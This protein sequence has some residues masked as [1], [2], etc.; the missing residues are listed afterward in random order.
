MSEVPLRR[1]I[2]G[3]VGVL[4]EEGIVALKRVGDGRDSLL[5]YIYFREKEEK[6]VCE[7]IWP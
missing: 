5:E 4:P 6:V 3:V 1:V 2:L 7:V